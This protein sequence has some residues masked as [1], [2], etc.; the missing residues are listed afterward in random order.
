MHLLPDLPQ[1]TLRTHTHN[2]L[3]DTHGE[4]DDDEDDVTRVGVGVI[5]DMLKDIIGKEGREQGE[6]VIEEIE[7]ACPHALA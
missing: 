2:R 5:T 3:G 1:L 7:D 4:S 6:L